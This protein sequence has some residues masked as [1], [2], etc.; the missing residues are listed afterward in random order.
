M[1]LLT[2]LLIVAVLVAGVLIT[3]VWAQEV[4]LE[5]PWRYDLGFAL[6]VLDDI[7][8]ISSTT[9]FPLG[10]LGACRLTMGFASYTEGW[11][12]FSQE[13]NSLFLGGIF[14]PKGW[15]IEF[16]DLP[17]IGELLVNIGLGGN[18]LTSWIRSPLFEET[19]TK[20]LISAVGESEYQLGRMVFF[21]N[22]G[23]AIRI[24]KFALLPTVA[25]GIEWRY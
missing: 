1:K 6:K 22:L 11:W 15:Q 7:A 18:H 12:I 3:P 21:S 19:R 24:G 17:L 9:K 14:F 16:E 25:L 13:V 23:L 8:Y 5:K 2:S 4:S 20:L 10:D